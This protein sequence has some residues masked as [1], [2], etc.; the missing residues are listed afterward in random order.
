MNII[1]KIK[2]LTN[3][4]WDDTRWFMR[5]FVITSV[6]CGSIW[7][8]MLLLGAITGNMAGI[9]I[10]TVSLIVCYIFFKEAHTMIDNGEK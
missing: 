9:I 3:M 4:I 10:M 1:N 7:S 5:N 8:I 6:I 2:Q